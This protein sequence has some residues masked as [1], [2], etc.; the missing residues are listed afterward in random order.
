MNVYVI[1]KDILCAYCLL[2]VSLAFGKTLIR[3]C[4][5]VTLRYVYESQKKVPTFKL[6]I[7]YT[8]D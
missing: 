7:I 3:I 2:L 6:T 5:L 1:P 8:I 4:K